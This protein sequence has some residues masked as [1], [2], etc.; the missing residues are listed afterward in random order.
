MPFRQNQKILLPD[1]SAHTGSSLLHLKLTKIP[2]S[3]TP[4]EATTT[5]H[6]SGVPQLVAIL[7]EGTCGRSI[8]LLDYRKVVMTT[9]NA[10]VLGFKLLLSLI[11]IAIPGVHGGEIAESWGFEERSIA[12]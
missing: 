3:V 10:N 2:L 1:S 11:V 12:T 6:I 4:Y 8:N 7:F 9:T 5:H